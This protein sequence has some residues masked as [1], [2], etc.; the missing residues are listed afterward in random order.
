[1]AAS[2][3]PS[4]EKVLRGFVEPFDRQGGGGVDWL[5]ALRRA[6]LARFQELGLPTSGHEDWRFTPLAPLWRLP[7]APAP[8]GGEVDPASLGS[9]TF[10][11][12]QGPRL[13]FVDGW[14]APGLSR[15][16]PLPPG[17]TV[18]SLAGR[19]EGDGEQLKPL[20]ARQA[21]TEEN[22]F[23]VLNAAYFTDGGF[24]Q[25]APGAVMEEPVVLCF[26]STLP[27]AAT[28]P[29]TV[30]LA[31]RDSRLTVLECYA[32]LTDA[33]TFTNAMTDVVA[34]EGA[35][36]EHLRFQDENGSTVHLGAVQGQFGASSQVSLHSFA[37]GSRLARNSLRTHLGGAG[38]E[39]IL[40]GLYLTHGEQVVDHHMVVEHA[41]PHCASHEYFNGILDD[42]SR[43][44]FHG[45][46][47]VRPEAQKT[48]AKQTN[49]NI[50]LSDEAQV[51]TKPQLEI[52][53][54]DVKCT[55]GATVGQL[56]EDSIFY[57]RA[58][59][60]G[61]ERAKR[62]LI[63]SFAGEIIQRVRCVPAREELDRLVWERLEQ[64]PHVADARA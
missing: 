50:L 24:I 56:N 60:V 61:L 58:R 57:L 35:Q 2:K 26:L 18:G 4:L 27:G 59:G 16:G 46:I 55:H 14:Y 34:E 49:K 42:R 63:H 52:Y 21:R 11:A 3:T 33:G 29:R 43:G 8:G 48:D 38:L 47:L 51:N 23:T 9:L 64:N 54:D 32:S 25:A 31:G 30:V 45:R 7:F 22:P 53:A 40:N 37:L 1:M 36:V 62:M 6:G 17:I 15:V 19:L 10:A 44:V 20:L 5:A 12:I 28:Q 41:Q 39:C 13:V